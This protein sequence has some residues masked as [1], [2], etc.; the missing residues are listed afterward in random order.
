[1]VMLI[2]GGYFMWNALSELPNQRH[3]HE[4]D[5][6]E[7]YHRFI[8]KMKTVTDRIVICK[9]YKTWRK[10]IYPEYKAHRKDDKR[11]KKIDFDKVFK[12]LEEYLDYFEKNGGNVYHLPLA[13]ADDLIYSFSVRSNEPVCII[14]S[15][16]D[17]TQLLNNNIVQFEP[18]FKKL[19]IENDCDIP[20]TMLDTF[21]DEFQAMLWKLKGF[22]ED[23]EIVRVDP[24]AVVVE[25]LIVGDKSDNIDSIVMEKRGERTYRYPKKHI[26]KIINA[27]KDRKFNLNDLTR[28]EVIEFLHE[29]AKEYHDLDGKSSLNNLKLNQRLVLMHRANYP[30]D[31]FEKLITIEMNF[32]SLQ[33]FDPFE[34]DNLGDDSE[35]FDDSKWGQFLD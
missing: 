7:V 1:M 20:Q 32:K 33:D 2:D 13:E 4:G 8:E 24:V 29:T 21:N 22:D 6:I 35:G 28:L 27:V 11:K 31:L 9:D 25:K 17:L 18:K 3:F 5:L 23:I 10:S 16:R 34:L 30:E 26:W 19:F 14:S 12:A 15:D